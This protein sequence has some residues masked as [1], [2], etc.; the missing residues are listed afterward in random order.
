MNAIKV[1]TIFLRA[2]SGGV[3]CIRGWRKEPVSL[4]VVQG[5]QFN[6]R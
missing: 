1:A 2:L 4:V 3:D 6:V 5:S